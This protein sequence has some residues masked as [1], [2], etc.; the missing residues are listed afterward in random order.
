MGSQ[1]WAAKRQ[2]QQPRIESEQRKALAKAVLLGS[3]LQFACIG[4]S[5][6]VLTELSWA[7]VLRLEF[8]PVFK[9]WLLQPVPALFSNTCLELAQESRPEAG[10]FS[11]FSVQPT[12][13]PEISPA[14]PREWSCVGLAWSHGFA[15]HDL[16]VTG[17]HISS[18][19]STNCVRAV[20]CH[21][22][23]V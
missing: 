8:Q 21:Q 13:V 2:H 18:G 22:L 14:G 6:D 1:G 19:L 16:E 23:P 17:K 10:S 7:L 20:L 3:C 15:Q 11:G 5:S 12:R 4:T 9:N